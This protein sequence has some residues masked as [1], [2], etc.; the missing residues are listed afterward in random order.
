[1]QC[2]LPLATARQIYDSAL[3]PDI[4]ARTFRHTDMLFPTRTIARSPTAR[5]L[6][7]QDNPLQNFV[8]AS[9]GKTY[10][11]YDFLSI[12]RVSGMLVLKNGANC[13]ETYQLG[14]TE[15][16]HWMSMSIAKTVTATLAGVAIKDGYIKSLD[17]PISH[18]LPVLQ[19]SAYNG[20]T[21]HQL[22]TMCSGVQWDETYTNPQS[23]RR[24]MLDLQ[25]AQQPGAIVDMMSR[26]PRA[27]TPGSRW[28]YSTG[29]THI[30]GAMVR[31]AVQ[32]PLADYFSE[33][34]WSRLGTEADAK[35]W[36]ESP[37]GLEVGG[38]GISASLRDYARFGL[39]LLNQ[40]VIDGVE[41]LPAG[42]I[43]AAS[44]PITVGGAKVDYGY[45]LWPLPHYHPIHHGAF[46][47]IGIFGQ[48]LYVNPE[49]NLVAMVWGALP[50]PMFK[51]QTQIRIED[52]FAGLCVALD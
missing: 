10:D 44:Q 46:Q 35:W 1:M 6:P 4:Q 20:V 41:V 51:D 29:E 23:D 33:K 16:T 17:D 15:K 32:R 7:T 30:A 39:F 37:N 8:F 14:N 13:F 38:S 48:H 18:Y 12:N 11:L 36:L 21:V 52:F 22:L 45:M 31:A 2:E 40:G 25:I 5:P 27:A 34:I 50:K 26:L 47:A 49:Q 9:Q 28:N 24:R 42:W 19:H 3:L 43:Q